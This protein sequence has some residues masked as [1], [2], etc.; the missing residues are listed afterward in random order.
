VGEEVGDA[1]IEKY[2][3]DAHK[4]LMRMVAI[5]RDLLEFS[6]TAAGTAEPKSISEVLT[7]VKEAL[8]AAAEKAGV[9]ISVECPAE[10]PPIRSGI[11]FQVVLNLVKNAVEAMPKGGRVDMRAAGGADAFT[12]EVADTGPGIPAEAMR[13]IFEP[14]YSLKAS[15]QGTGLGL[16]ICKDLVEKQGGTIKAANRPEGGAVFTVR[17][18]LTPK[19]GA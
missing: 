13:R 5:V 14:F 4:G 11:L 18:P 2:L 3:A 19:A 9:R 6:R 16:V 12:I 8:A 15:G 7:E 17:I 1:R 10:L